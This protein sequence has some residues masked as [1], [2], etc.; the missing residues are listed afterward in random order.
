MNSLSP[1]TQLC[2]ANEKSKAELYPA[3]GARSG[4]AGRRGALLGPA[5][6]RSRG[7]PGGD[8]T[9]PKRGGAGPPGGCRTC[10]AAR[11]GS[12]GRGRGGSLAWF[13]FRVSLATIPRGRP[14]RLGVYSL[15][16]RP[17]AVKQSLAP[18]RAGQKGRPW[19]SAKGFQHPGRAA[20]P[21]RPRLGASFT[22]NPALINRALNRP[23][24]GAPSAQALP[25]GFH[26]SHPH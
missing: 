19:L 13:I 11:G 24:P 8:A 17:P 5:R 10:G 23:C 4:G 22:R 1:I 20:Q 9:P 6:R 14:L 18:G 26:T 2:L 21:R 15:P 7:G 25:T 3:Q 16:T 12:A